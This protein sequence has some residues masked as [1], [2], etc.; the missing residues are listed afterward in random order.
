MILDWRTSPEIAAR[1]ETQVD[2]DIERQKAWIQSCNAKKDYIHFVISLEDT[3]EPVGYLSY[4]NI[5]WTKKT[6]VNGFYLVLEQKKRSLATF[7]HNFNADYCFYALKMETMLF[8][9]RDDNIGILKGLEVRNIH[10]VHKDNNLYFFERKRADFI[11]DKRLFTLER[12]L[13]NF[14]DI[15][16]EPYAK[17]IGQD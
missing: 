17:F 12:T 2:Y 7:V 3:R 16:S 10:P 13:A 8:S 1:M 14:P 5:D 9:V 6:C 15:A 11:A 4:A